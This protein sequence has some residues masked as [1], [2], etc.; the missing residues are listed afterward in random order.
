MGASNE[1]EADG[2]RLPKSIRHKHILEIAAEK[3]EASL[4]SIANEVPSATAD[5]VE[6]VLDEYGDPASN[7]GNDEEIEESGSASSVD[8]DASGDDESD[9]S[10][11]K[12]TSDV[13]DGQPIPSSL[14]LTDGQR[15]VLLAVYENPEATQREIGAILDV[16]AATICNRVKTIEDFDWD[17]RQT[18]VKEIFDSPDGK[19]ELVPSNM[20]SNEPDDAESREE[21]LKRVTVLEEQLTELE[22][23]T[24]SD[25]VDHLGLD[26]EL[27][28]KLMHACLTSDVIT[29]DEEL[30][31]LKTLLR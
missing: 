31:I 24:D 17:H 9:D 25:T 6:Y 11:E 18:F 23:K 29:E 15:E 28:H 12:W 10:F 8:D 26:A 19:S 16:S 14:D 2:R 5:L 20:E 1:S 7:D 4:E 30:R 21:L 27:I 3:P 13:N 22:T